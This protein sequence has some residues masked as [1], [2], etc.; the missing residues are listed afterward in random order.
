MKKTFKAVLAL[1]L[2]MSLLFCS[3]C[4]LKGSTK[5]LDANPIDTLMATYNVQYPVQNTGA[6][7]EKKVRA[8][9]ISDTGEDLYYVQARV[10]NNDEESRLTA[11]GYGYITAEPVAENT[12]KLIFFNV[13]KN[14]ANTTYRSVITN[15][16][17]TADIL[18][19][20]QEPTVKVTPDSIVFIFFSVN[21]KYYVG[22]AT[23]NDDFIFWEIE[24]HEPED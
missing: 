11:F 12:K 15:G 5:V 1:S 2:I 6:N 21:D 7:V 22:G 17:Y 13:E 18:Y 3:G 9:I 20:V 24:N 19:E 10:V 16:G 14:V 8:Q 4:N 23:I